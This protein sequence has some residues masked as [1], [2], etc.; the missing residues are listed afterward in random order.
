MDQ[1][2]ARFTI[3]YTGI[4]EFAISSYVKRSI[5]N[6]PAALT[7]KRS[8][9]LWQALSVEEVWTKCGE[10]IYIPYLQHGSGI[11]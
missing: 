8:S 6:I 9:Y 4:D 3:F 1:E 2:T 10:T 5:S 11:R 7:K